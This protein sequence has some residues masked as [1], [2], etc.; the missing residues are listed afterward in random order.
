MLYTNYTKNHNQVR[1]IGNH[2][3]GKNAEFYKNSAEKEQE[4]PGAAL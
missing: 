4:I 3:K 1:F 2:G